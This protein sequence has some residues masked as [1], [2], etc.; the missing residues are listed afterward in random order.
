[1]SEIRVD[2]ITEKTS[3]N[4]V[5]I[6]SVTLKDGNVVVASAATG[7]P[8][9]TSELFDDYE[10]G[11]WSPVVS[12][13]TNNATMAS[14]SDK[15]WYTKNG[16]IVTIGCYLG[17]SSKGSIADAQTVRIHG[18]PFAVPNTS[19]SNED[20]TGLCNGAYI[21]GMTSGIATKTIGFYT[22]KNTSYLQGSCQDGAVAST[23]LRGDEI[24][25]SFA[26]MVG[27]SYKTDL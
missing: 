24:T 18:L 14:G 8:T 26:I 21:A 9:N 13:G 10:E 20:Y 6:D 1:M 16:R 22:E 19:S 25:D 3:A 4:G 12:D 17:I 23:P 11:V 27:G 7:G 2:T 15:G 5:A